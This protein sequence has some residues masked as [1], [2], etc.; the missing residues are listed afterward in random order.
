MDQVD[1]HGAI[2]GSAGRSLAGTGPIAGPQG[3]TSPGHLVPAPSSDNGDEIWFFANT[4]RDQVN[5]VL[6]PGR[7]ICCV[8]TVSRGRS[9]QL[10]NDNSSDRELYLELCLGGFP[11]L[12]ATAG[13]NAMGSSIELARSSFPAGY[14]SSMNHGPLS[15][16]LPTPCAWTSASTGLVT[17]S[18]RADVC[19]LCPW[20]I[21][22]SWVRLGENFHS[23]RN[24]VFQ[25]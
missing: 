25:V 17:A 11:L 10:D 16:W 22:T 6:S 18:E 13:P 5:S 8:W 23:A 7:N 2:D 24:Q 19:S 4:N 20:G 15:A 21:V 9:Y 1:C 3:G 14:W 12:L